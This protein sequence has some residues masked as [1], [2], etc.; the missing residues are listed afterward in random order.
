[1]CFYGALGQNVT[2]QS[3]GLCG[4]AQS[5]LRGLQRVF[6]NP[7]TIKWQSREPPGACPV[8]PFL[9]DKAAARPG[10]RWSSLATVLGFEEGNEGIWETDLQCPS[11]FPALPSL[12]TPAVSVKVTA[13]ILALASSVHAE[14]L[15]LISSSFLSCQRFQQP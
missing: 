11:C 9:S 10:L 15:L 7:G 12:H 2:I 8:R 1:M 5:V 3:S 6:R 14:P 13:Q 4:E